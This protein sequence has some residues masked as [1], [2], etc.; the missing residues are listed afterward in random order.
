MLI[1]E[2][3]DSVK[4][5]LIAWKV[6]WLPSIIVN[7]IRFENGDTHVSKFKNYIMFQRWPDATEQK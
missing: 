4:N 1:V 6:A 2:F 7:I 5:I 3:V